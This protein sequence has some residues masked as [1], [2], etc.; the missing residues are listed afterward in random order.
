MRHRVVIWPRNGRCIGRRVLADT[1]VTADVPEATADLLHAIYERIVVVGRSIVGVCLTPWVTRTASRLRCL[2]LSWRARQ[3]LGA[4][5]QP[6]RSRSRAVTSG[7]PRR[8]GWREGPP[9]RARD[10]PRGRR[11]RRGP[12]RR[13]GEG[14]RPPPRPV[15]LDREAPPSERAVQGGSGDDG[16]TR[17]DPGAVAARARGPSTRGRMAAC[18]TLRSGSSASSPAAGRARCQPP[19]D[20]RRGICGG[21]SRGRRPPREGDVLAA[22]VAAGG[23]VADADE[24]VG[25][26]V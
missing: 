19:L 2:R 12:R 6:T 21:R 26:P 18:S 25:N 7:W 22:F 10:G 8:G 23:S 20:E 15:A 4:R 24:T 13:V 3:V 17:V 16:A 5:Q 9:H 1:R 14:R 11:G